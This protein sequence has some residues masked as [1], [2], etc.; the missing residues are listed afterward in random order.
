M[1]SIPIPNKFTSLNN[2]EI[3]Y[4]FYSY[5]GLQYAVDMLKGYYDRYRVRGQGK[6]HLFD[7]KCHVLKFEII[8]HF[9]HYADNLE[10]SLSLS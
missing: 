4:N 8:A 6:D 1:T 7:K 5:D 3:L 2:D 9:C 10:S